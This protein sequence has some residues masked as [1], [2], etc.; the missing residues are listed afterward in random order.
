MSPNEKLFPV[1]YASEL[2]RI[3]EGDL[4]SARGLF[5]AQEGRNEKFNCARSKYSGVGNED[6][7]LLIGRSC[8]GAKGMI[9]L[10]KS[11]RLQMEFPWK[12]R[13]T[14]R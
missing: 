3:A 10:P 14:W 9:K 12:M 7:K 1:S 5:K 13:S 2:L 6:Y 8:S 11:L 4:H